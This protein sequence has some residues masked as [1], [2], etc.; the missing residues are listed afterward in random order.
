MV[1]AQS[2]HCDGFADDGSRWRCPGETHGFDAV[3][4]NGSAASE[5]AGHP[6]TLKCAVVLEALK[7]QPLRVADADSTARSKCDKH[8]AGRTIEPAEEMIGKSITLLI[9]P[10][11]AA[12]SPSSASML[13]SPI[14]TRSPSS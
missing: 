5:L 11:N 6:D 4:Q 1:S 2:A 3:V 14:R 10:I 7:D 9:P 12:N 13:L 8:I